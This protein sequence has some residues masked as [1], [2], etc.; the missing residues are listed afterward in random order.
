M[1]WPFVGTVVCDVAKSVMQNAEHLS[2]FVLVEV[3]GEQLLE[4][5]NHAT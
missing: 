1:G 2:Q 4:R 3:E 5:G